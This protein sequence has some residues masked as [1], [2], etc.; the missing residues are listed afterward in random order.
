MSVKWSQEIH[1]NAMDLPK[2]IFTW[3]D[4]KKIARA[5]KQSSDTSSRTKGTKFA[6]A[7]RMLTFYINR[8]GTKLDAEQKKILIEAKKELRIIY[9]RPVLTK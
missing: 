3:K 5:L 9:H 1:S 2:G 6:S 8:A 7:M 4:P